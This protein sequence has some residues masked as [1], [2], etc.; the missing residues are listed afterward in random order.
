MRE[1]IFF[2][3]AAAVFVADLLTKL[4]VRTNMFP[5]E[6]IPRDAAIR[7]TYITNTGSAF[8]LFQNQTLFLVITAI[9]GIG[10]IVFY[11][12]AHS[13][14]TLPLTISLG[15]QLG[16]AT[17]NLVERLQRGQVTDFIDLRF[18]PVFNI[19]DSCI[20]IGVATLAWFLFL[21]ARKGQSSQS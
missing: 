8:G 12:M 4:W 21:P 2:S 19:A 13:G 17:G 1:A 10:A 20:V 3:I 11:H 5:G 7:L 16:G 15:L 18:W 6:S 14:K 9:I